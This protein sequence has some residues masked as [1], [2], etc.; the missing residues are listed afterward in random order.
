MSSYYKVNFEL[1]NNEDL[2][3]SFA[4]CDKSGVPVSLADAAL[5]MQ[6]RGLSGTTVIEASIANG[7]VSVINP[8]A[9]TFRLHVPAETMSGIAEGAYH[10]DLLL[11]SADGAVKRIWTGTL[12]LAQGVTQ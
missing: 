10:H 1:S 4:I 7:R 8:A 12:Q 3:Q 11:S 6:V 5:K 2:D 9:G